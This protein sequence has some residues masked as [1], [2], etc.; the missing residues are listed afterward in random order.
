MDDFFAKELLGNTVLQYLYSVGFLLGAIALILLFRKLILKRLTSYVSNT[1]NTVDDFLV[2]LVRRGLI[3]FLYSLSVYT[4]VKLLVVPLAVLKAADVLLA[5]VVTIIFARCLSEFIAYCFASYR[6]KSGIGDLMEKSFGGILT[7]V[8]TIVWGLAI[9]LFLDN[10]GIK[11]STIIAGL[12]IGGVAV[13]LAAQTILKDLFSYVCIL[14]DRP[15][16]VG[17]FIIVGDYLGTVEYIGIKTT[18][19][20]SLGGEQ[21]IFSNADLTDSRVRNYKRMEK[22]RVVFS[23]G[24]TYQTSSDKLKQIPEMVKTMIEK[25]EDTVFD[26]AHF[27]KYG[28]SSLDFE[29]VYYVLSGDYNKY[30]DIQQRVNLDIF[31]QFTAQNIEFAYPTRTLYLNKE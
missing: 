27:A 18:R 20:A 22:R 2:L 28:D 13:A 30:M 8:Q 12:G 19:I 14:F 6:Q 23:F 15:F 26:R 17:D 11:I 1:S 21:L 10:I 4:S 24:V 9:A 3:P 25:I 7:V 31:D 29:V 5:A 16:T